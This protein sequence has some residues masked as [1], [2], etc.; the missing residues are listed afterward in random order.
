MGPA[1][2]IG[3]FT[4]GL[5]PSD[6]SAAS[7][8]ASRVESTFLP[9]RSSFSAPLRISGN[10]QPPATQIRKA[11]KRLDV[12]ASK[13]KAKVD[14]WKRPGGG[15][16]GGGVVAVE[17]RVLKQELLAG[18]APQGSGAVEA[19]EEV[20][21]GMA[22]QEGVA[23]ELVEP[24]STGGI[25]AD[26]ESKLREEA[27]DLGATVAAAEVVV[28][29]AEGDASDQSES[30]GSDDEES[31]EGESSKDLGE[32]FLPPMTAIERDTLALLEWDKVSEQVAQFCDTPMA[33][34]QA[35][36]SGLPLGSSQE[37]SES[38]LQET[39]SALHLPARLNFEGAADISPV[40]RR[41]AKRQKLSNDDPTK[42]SRLCSVPDLCAVLSFLDCADSLY[43]QLGCSEAA[44]LTGQAGGEHEENGDGRGGAGESK[45]AVARALL[46]GAAWE[47]CLA[48]RGEIQ[49]CVNPLLRSITDEAS[50]ELTQVRVHLPPVPSELRNRKHRRA[51]LPF[52]SIAGLPQAGEAWAG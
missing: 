36:T 22:G 38:L 5:H 26:L 30:D 42:S 21:N 14:K 7:A 35:I 25:A 18:G 45:V 31:L 40:L 44:G 46:Q 15:E 11:S 10:A 51:A 50:P 16:S 29:T 28:E 24:E 52:Q 32:A 34:Q 9:K 39:E 48:V 19:V 20:Q 33:Y 6:S 13:A 4:L 2:L 12:S 43:R 47:E 37:E 27:D 17:E 49:R 8:A 1:R 3:S 23:T 41:L